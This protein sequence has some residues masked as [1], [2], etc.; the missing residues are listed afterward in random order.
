MTI[1]SVKLEIIHFF[2]PLRVIYFFCCLSFSCSSFFSCIF[3][4]S[5]TLQF[6]DFS[7]CE[8]CKNSCELNLAHRRHLLTPE[9]IYSTSVFKQYGHCPHITWSPLT[10]IDDYKNSCTTVCLVPWYCMLSYEDTWPQ[11]HRWGN[12]W[13]NDYKKA[14]N[15]A[16]SSHL[17]L[18]AL[19]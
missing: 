8:L 1:F 19:V 16:R 3:P 5:L 15:Q 6:F 14:T 4:L 2:L 10:E 18:L 9:R 12:L 11:R 17:L 7:L 13:L